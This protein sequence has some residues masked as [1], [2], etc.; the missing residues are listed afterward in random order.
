MMEPIEVIIKKEKKPWY[1]NNWVVI[2]LL[3][4]FP[5]IGIP[6]MWKFADYSGPLKVI[7][8]GMELIGIMYLSAQYNTFWLIIILIA[9]SIIL[10]KFVDS[11][12]KW[13]GGENVMKKKI[14]I[15]VGVVVLGFFV[16]SAIGGSSNKGGSA[17][18]TT[19]TSTNTTKPAPAMAK[20]GEAVTDKDLSFTVSEIKTASSVGNSY[21]KKDAQGIFTI[22]TVKIANNT[23]ETKTIDSSAFQIVDSQ[24]RK[25]DRSIEGQ[26]AKGMSQGQVDLF[27]QQVQPSL[28]VTGDV[29]FDIPKDA[30]GLKLL[31]K[32]S[33]FSSGTEI[34]LGK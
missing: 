32:G 2:P 3:L 16:I 34:D 19:T 17:P 12:F 14:L 23:K 20:I 25:F 7:L 31:V 26:T 29:V 1:R 18:T 21:T 5:Y 28:S 33:L 24:G 27:L 30:T 22:V 4:G 10:S 9:S 13:K 8:T 15:G 6:W 11:D